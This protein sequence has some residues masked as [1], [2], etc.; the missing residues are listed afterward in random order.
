MIISCVGINLV[1]ITH[2]VAIN[3]DNDNNNT[4][5][6]VHKAVS[7]QSHWESS[8]GSRDECSPAPSGHHSL[9]QANWLEA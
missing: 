8:V 3:N 1:Y 2:G 9:D 4:V 6:N 7:C 5:D